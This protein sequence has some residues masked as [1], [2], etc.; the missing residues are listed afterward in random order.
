M[1][2]LVRSNHFWL[3]LPDLT[4]P[5]LSCPDTCTI[6]PLLLVAL[7]S[8]KKFGSDVNVLSFF[9]ISTEGLGAVEVFQLVL[10]VLFLVSV[11]HQSIPLLAVEEASFY[12]RIRSR[13]K[14]VALPK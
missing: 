6:N 9:G 3:A 14:S 1:G 11:R 13:E 2:F 12:P 7:T 8:S 4:C 5:V 10:L